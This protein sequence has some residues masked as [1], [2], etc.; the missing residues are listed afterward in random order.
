MIAR[1]FSVRCAL[2]V[3]LLAALSSAQAADLKVRVIDAAGNPAVGVAVLVDAQRMKPDSSDRP[4]LE[5]RQR[6]LRFSPAL[7][8]VP[9][10]TE[11][12]FTN[13]D[14]FDHHVVGRSEKTR[15]EFSVPAVE[16]NPNPKSKV[17]KRAPAVA[18]LSQSGVVALSCHLHSSMRAHILVT[19]AAYSGVT[20]AKGEIRFTD[21]HGGQAAINTWHPLLL[22]RAASTVAHV[23]DQ[24]AE[25]TIRL[26]VVL[27]AP[28]R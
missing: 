12:L 21:L 28:R 4:R 7:S 14:D 22:T 19:E 18:V 2:W 13:D 8:V 17:A 16:A 10:G 5:I 26:N 6:N 27:P 1:M 11:V 24:A 23:G 20:D 9:V 15:F 3:A 25:A